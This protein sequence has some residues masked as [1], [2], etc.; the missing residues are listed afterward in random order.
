MA[1]VRILQDAEL[2]PASI[3]NSDMAAV[4]LREMPTEE[5][6]LL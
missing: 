4:L 2:K 6:L 5:S 3:P 1:I